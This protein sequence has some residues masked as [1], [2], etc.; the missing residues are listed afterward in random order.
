MPF[1]LIDIFARKT[2]AIIEADVSSIGRARVKLNTLCGFDP[3]TLLLKFFIYQ[4]ILK[5]GFI[6]NEK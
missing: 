4:F 3:H 6:P 2:Y 5:G 1:L